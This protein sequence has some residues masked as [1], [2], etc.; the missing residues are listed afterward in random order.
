MTDTDV[1]ERAI[2][3]VVAVQT[4]HRTAPRRPGSERGNALEVCIEFCGHTS[5]RLVVTVPRTLLA[6]LF[7]DHLPGERGAEAELIEALEA[8]AV[9]ICEHALHA[10]FGIHT[11]ELAP[12]RTDAASL[13]AR[14]AVTVGV[15][16]HWIAA[17]L[18]EDTL[19]V[20]TRLRP[21]PLPALRVASR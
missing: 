10:A 17:E 19:S 14:P 3:A 9:A 8:L 18:V 21:T 20:P 15:L 4:G 6:P 2:A 5:G 16:D 11:F 12:P 13:M 7:A 1:L